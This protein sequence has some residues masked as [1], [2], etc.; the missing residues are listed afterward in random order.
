MKIEGLLIQ[1]VRT[2]MSKELFLRAFFFVMLL[3][4]LP[5]IKINIFI[6]PGFLA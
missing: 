4:P 5:E 6:K 2:S 3:F 1:I